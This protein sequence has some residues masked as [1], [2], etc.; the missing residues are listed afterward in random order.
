MN[1]KNCKKSKCSKVQENNF[2]QKKNEKK[3]NHFKLLFF[4]INK[5]I[6]KQ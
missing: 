4:A 3:K 5:N 2:Y 6:K 1:Q